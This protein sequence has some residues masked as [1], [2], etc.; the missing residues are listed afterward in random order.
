MSRFFNAWLTEIDGGRAWQ[1]LL[2]DGRDGIGP[3][4]GAAVN[5]AVAR[6][7]PR[8]QPAADAQ[9]QPQGG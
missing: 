3:D 2:D 5:A 7:A 1:A 8:N 9:P 4:P 6:R